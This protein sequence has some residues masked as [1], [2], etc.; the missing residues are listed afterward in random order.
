MKND[1]EKQIAER[2]GKWADAVEQETLL[3]KFIIWY[4]K[5]V[6]GKPYDISAEELIKNYKETCK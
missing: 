4:W 5:E 6:Q 2:I 3:K 1:A